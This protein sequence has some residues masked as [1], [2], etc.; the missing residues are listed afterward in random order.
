MER[1]LQAVLEERGDEYQGLLRDVAD[2]PVGDA[3]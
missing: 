1:A 2:S 3:A